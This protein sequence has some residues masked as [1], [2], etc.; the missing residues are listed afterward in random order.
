M[1]DATRQEAIEWCHDNMADFKTPVFPTPE[2]WMWAESGDGLV[3]IAIFTNT[4]DADITSADAR[5]QPSS[6]AVQ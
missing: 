5:V 3:L 2:G 4:E 6:G 1:R